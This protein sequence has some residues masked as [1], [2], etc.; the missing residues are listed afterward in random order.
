MRFKQLCT[1][2]GVEPRLNIESGKKEFW[3]LKDLRKTCATYYDEH[4]PGSSV[5][6]LGHYIRGITYRHYAHRD[7]LAVKAIMTI[8]QPS[9]FTGLAKRDWKCHSGDHQPHT[10]FRLLSDFRLPRYPE[11]ADKT[12]C[13]HISV[14]SPSLRCSS[15]VSSARASVPR[16][17]RKTRGNQ[18]VSPT[19]ERF[20]KFFRKISANTPI[21]GGY[22]IN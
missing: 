8:P 10:G 13:L 15:R 18:P 22:G 6:I 20:L 11:Q 7:P 16:G 12:H 17:K 2:A 5:E 3:Q 21:I 19:G 14:K 9:A 4:I 1:L